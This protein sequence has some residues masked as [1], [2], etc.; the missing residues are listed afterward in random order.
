MAM[1]DDRLEVGTNTGPRSNPSD[2]DPGLAA[3]KAEFSLFYENDFPRLVA[4]LTVHGVPIAT[5]TDVAQE[6]MTEAFRQ[7]DSLDAPRAWVRKVAAR[8]WWRRAQRDE[9]EAP[10]ERLP[11]GEVILQSDVALEIEARHDFVA[12]VKR[13]PMA[14]RQ[15]IAWTYDGF[16]PTE[17]AAQLGK[18]PATVRSLLRKARL[19]VGLAY[20]R[21]DR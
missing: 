3:R 10:T 11:E 1:D 6:A 5:A 20:D 13:L 4:F 7:W 8:M 15:V 17:I 18:S 21:E 16:Q 2:V 14:Q 9:R 19:A 12:L